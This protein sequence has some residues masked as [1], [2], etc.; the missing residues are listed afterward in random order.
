LNA[1][2][3]SVHV[4]SLEAGSSHTNWSMIFD[5]THGE[6][7]SAAKAKEQ[8]VRR[9][10]PAI[11]AFIR[12]SG[13]DVH[14][15]SDLTQGFICDVVIGRKLFHKADPARGRFRSLLLSALQNYL[16]EQH[17]R[18]TRS[19]RAPSEGH[20]VP[21]DTAEA[22]A[23]EIDAT[24]SPEAAFCSQWTNTLIRRV[25]DIV[26]EECERDGLQ[27]HWEVFNRRVVRPMLLGET[28]TSYGALV[29]RLDLADAAQA[30]NMM[31]TV[32]RRF[33]RTLYGEVSKTVTDPMQT[34]EELRA[35]LRDLERPA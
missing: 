19:K 23:T 27:T 30:A 28:P 17:R 3:W 21:I 18:A 6:D 2:A 24:D 9:Y 5:A 12:R 15:A 20:T 8:L 32:K 34:E 25:L 16:R 10:W 35:L 31:V 11:Y 33:A 14:E 29:E 22:M 1:F 13:R 4:T 7:E 26:R